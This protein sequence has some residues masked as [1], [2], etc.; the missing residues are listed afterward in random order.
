MPEVTRKPD[1]CTGHGCYPPRV[2]AAWSPDVF[3]N[4]QNVMRQGDPYVSHGCAVCAPHGGNI[5]VGS[6]TVFAN[7]KQLARTG[8]PIDCGSSCGAHSPDVF[9]GG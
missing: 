5:A 6:G 7:A 2:P 9:A 1:V 3:A 4:A 8:D